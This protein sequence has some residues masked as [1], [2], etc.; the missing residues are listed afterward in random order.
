[1]Q[2]RNGLGDYRKVYRVTVLALLLAG[3]S[4]CSSSAAPTRAPS[5]GGSGGSSIAGSQ[6][7]NAAGVGASI[8]AGGATPGGSSTT[9][10]SSTVPQPGASGDAGAGGDD[11]EPPLGGEWPGPQGWPAGSLLPYYPTNYDEPYRAQFHYTA[12][13][14]W[15]NDANG[16]WFYGGVYHLLHQAYPYTLAEGPKSWGH[17][18]ST[19]LLHWAPA[20]L[21]LVPGVNIPG[22]AAW[23]GSTVM[24]TN[25]TSGLQSGKN[26]VL[27]TVY[28]C[29]PL[30]ICLN[31]SNDLGLTWQ[32]YQ[33]NPVAMQG[34][35]PHVLWHAATK[36]WV[37]ATANQDIT[38][39][40]T[41]AD[42]RTWKPSG[43]VAFG[44]DCPDLFELAVDGNDGDR[45]WALL[46]A[47]GQYL[48][49]QFDGS[50]FQQAPGG[51]YN[52]DYGPGFYAS[53]TFFRDTFPDARLVQIAW[54]NSNDVRDPVTAP[55]NQV[56]SVPVELTLRTFPEGVRLSR[57]PIA[58][59]SQLHDDTKTWAAQTLAAGSNLLQGVQ[60][61]AFDLEL[62]LDTSQTNAS[63][64]DLHV[65][66]KVFSY[67][68][69]KGE[70]LGAKLSP[71]AGRLT[72]RFV[73]D[74]SELEIFGNDGQYSYTRSIGFAPGSSAL[75]LD[76]DGPLSIVSA[77][78]SRMQRI[79]S[80]TAALS[81]LQL[82]D[83]N[84][85][86]TYQG[87][88]TSGS[89]DRSYYLSTF[90]VGHGAG[91]YVE[92]QL[93]GT[94]LEWHGL[95]NTDTGMVDIWLD[96]TKLQSNVDTYA[97]IRQIATFPIAQGLP[98][99]THTVRI[100][101]TGSK[102]AASSGSAFVHD[103]FESYVDP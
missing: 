17:A 66:D 13:S 82:D 40:Y 72:L 46:R 67:D 25:N 29:P 57:K 41:S 73:V 64:I 45:R 4:R 33:G 37:A 36:Q 81:S 98:N 5:A 63:K 24:D 21:A 54:I 76:A 78:F 34:I 27:V 85:E 102:N 7:T 20:P 77:R 30:G 61:K 48:L 80:G 87:P 83:A 9:A 28:F 89:D 39:L 32:Q 16:L 55:Y 50:T 60:G 69:A 53:Q 70:L 35:D 38:R 51:P 79:F 42:L 11:S 1:M 93:S 31:Y 71:I 23:S 3:L 84:A 68:V 90:H 100:A 58:E 97:K 14:G 10:G 2:K 43:T 26:P 74:W 49:G 19:D 22:E 47:N 56:L 6:S 52:L 44:L 12:P 96:G 92:A 91:D 8:A 103:F 94:R 101:A 95:K 15:L 75:A 88:W 62:V 86:N 65:A 99:T 59:L 18:T